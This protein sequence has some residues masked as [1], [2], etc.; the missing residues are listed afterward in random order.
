MVCLYRYGREC[1]WHQVLGLNLR[2]SAFLSLLPWVV[3]AVGSTSAGLLADGLVKGGLPIATVRKV[4]I[5]ASAPSS[6][7][8][9]TVRL[10]LSFVSFEHLHTYRDLAQITENAVPL[11]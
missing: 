7:D 3:M 5:A 10:N 6:C 1:L 9:S 8:L 11:M 2:S 4:R